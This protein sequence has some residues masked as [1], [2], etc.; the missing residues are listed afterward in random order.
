MATV[1][2]PMT[3]E[4]MLAL[5]DNGMERWLIDG[6]LRER[7]MT[8]RNRFHRA[9]VS[10]VGQSPW[11]V[12]AAISLLPSHSR[13]SAGAVKM[14]S[15]LRTAAIAARRDGRPA[16]M[17]IDIINWGTPVS[18]AA[19]PPPAIISGDHPRLTRRVRIASSAHTRR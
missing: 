4:E 5:P 13:I 2:T 18:N 12:N 17:S 7:P 11:S 1:V 14:A 9:A 3:T 8:V 10:A 16:R 19:A 15:E 6:E